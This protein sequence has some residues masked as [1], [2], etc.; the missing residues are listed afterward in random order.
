MKIKTEKD[1]EAY[2]VSECEARGWD[3]IKFTSPGRNGMPDRIISADFN[4]IVFCEVK[5]PNGKGVLSANQEDEIAGLQ[6]R[7]HDVYVVETVEQVNQ[8]LM[9]ITN[10]EEFNRFIYFEYKHGN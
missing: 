3:A 4:T 2:L 7:Q 6:D 10:M 1:L 8:M 5:H 9:D